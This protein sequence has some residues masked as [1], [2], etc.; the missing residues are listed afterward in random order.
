MIQSYFRF[1]KH[2]VFT[3]ESS[4]LYC[5]HRVHESNLGGAPPGLGLGRALLETDGDGDGGL[6]D[7]RE[8]DVGDFYK[9]EEGAMWIRHLAKQAPPGNVT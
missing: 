7:H 9:E 2:F 5:A 3:R 6:D 1:H 4:N 8:E